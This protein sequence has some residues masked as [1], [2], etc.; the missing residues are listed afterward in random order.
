[1]RR[2]R[3]LRAVGLEI[4]R[5]RTAH[6]L[7]LQQLQELSGLHAGYIGGVERADRNAGMAAIFQLAR[8]LG[9]HPADLLGVLA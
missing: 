1:V 7:T 5:L 8:A 2:D 3:D 9:V 6:G 4:R